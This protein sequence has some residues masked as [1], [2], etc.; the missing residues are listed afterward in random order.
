MTAVDRMAAI[1]R[2][3]EILARPV[4][5]LEQKGDGANRADRRHL[6][7]HNDPWCARCKSVAKIV[8]A[9]P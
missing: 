5:V 1:R 9:T 6:K 2:A 4:D 7:H 8:G 3:D